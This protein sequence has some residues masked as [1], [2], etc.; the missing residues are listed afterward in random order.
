MRYLILI[1]CLLAGTASAEQVY[2][3]VDEDGVPTFS[4]QA[5]PGA[6]KVKIEEP[7]TFSDD[8]IHQEMDR[9][10]EEKEKIEEQARNVSYTIAITDPANDS[11]IRDNA[12]NLTISVRLQ[13]SLGDGHRAELYMDG[14]KIRSL[15]GT[16]SVHLSNVDRGT[17]QLSARVV[18]ANGRVLAESNSVEV[19][20]LRYSLPRKQPR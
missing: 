17:H 7:V 14:Q 20:L 3:Q 11:A 2:R 16:G 4:D 12:G 8:L 19:S 13:P 18:D 9:R 1:L 15:T 10:Q 5:L 6:E